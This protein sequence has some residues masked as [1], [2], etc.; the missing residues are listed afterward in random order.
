MKTIPRMGALLFA[1]AAACAQEPKQQEPKPQDA[2]QVL[3][4]VLEQ[5]KKEGIELDAKAQTVTI[6]AVVNEPQDPIEYVLI[7][8]R[9][10]KH[11]A[12]FWTKAKPSVLNAAL[13]MLGLTP[14]Q[15]AK[16]EEIKPPPSIEAI[17]KG[18]ETVTIT[19]PQ[20]MT[21]WMTVHWKT[22]EGKDVAFCLEDLVLDLRTQKPVVDCTWVFLGG[23]LAR[24][25]KDEPEVFAADLEG[26]LV[27]ACY[28][29]PENHL[30]TVS[31]K[32][33]RDQQNWW[34]TNKVPPPETEVRFVFHKQPS[35]LHK[36]REERL[37]KEAAAAKEPPAKPEEP[38]KE[39]PK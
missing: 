37:Q 13:L 4:Q 35:A 29:Y 11:E 27:S 24:F 17:E 39:P 15:N 20:G 10:K 33:G 1:V 3:Q 21:L 2:Q 16:A 5:F 36:A 26:N 30:V 38:K 25:Y 8:R 31:H 14:G 12:M 23:R 19:P 9:G 32:D 34:L 28:M 6:P 7:H 22:P 18:A